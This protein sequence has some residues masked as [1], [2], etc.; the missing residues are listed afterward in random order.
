MPKVQES[1]S[2]HAKFKDKDTLLLLR[3]INREK[4]DL[5]WY[6][7]Q[8]LLRYCKGVYNGQR[9]GGCNRCIN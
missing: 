6:K 5:L 4:I 9:R 3:F 1:Q 8:Y 7:K 2:R